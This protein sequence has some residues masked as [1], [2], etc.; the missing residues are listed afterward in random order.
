MRR[1]RPSASSPSSISTTSSARPS[2]STDRVNGGNPTWS[3]SRPGSSAERSIIRCSATASPSSTSAMTWSTTCRTASC[4][5]TRSIPT[6]GC[7]DAPGNLGTGK[8][9]FATLTLD[10]PLAKIGLKG[11]RVKFDG[12]LQRTRVDDPI[13]GEPRNWSRLLPR[14]AVERRSPPRYRQIVLWLHR[15]RPR[16]LHLLPHRRVRHQFQR[17]ALWNGLRRISSARRHDHHARSRQCARHVGQP[18]PADLP[19]EPRRSGSSLSTN[20]ASATAI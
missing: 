2:F 1:F 8:R 17:R 5:A 3:R 6:T 11:L 14:M 9:Y 16:A 15:Q 7:F 12:T 19:P 4:S 13:T 18:P 10:A 20:S